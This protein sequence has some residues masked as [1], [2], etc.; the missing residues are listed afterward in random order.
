M[1]KLL[2]VSNGE[3]LPARI[4]KAALIL[5]STLALAASTASVKAQETPAAMMQAEMPAGQTVQ[6]ASKA[7]F[8]AALCAAVKK[9]RGSS[10][11]L[12]SFAASL[13]PDSKKD[14]LRTVFRCLSE[15]GGDNCRLLGA[16]LRSLTAGDPNA[17]G[18]TD[19]ATQ[20]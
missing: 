5:V 13:R 17:S 10:P 4:F 2:M 8:L 16:V 9:H 12:A 15:G 18:L 7:D 1:K 6:T 14:I 20:L 11:A 19:L 3:H